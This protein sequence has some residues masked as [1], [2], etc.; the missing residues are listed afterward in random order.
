MDGQRA[1]HRTNAGV[2]APMPLMWHHFW[3]EMRRRRPVHRRRAL[4][5]IKIVTDSPLSQWVVIL[6]RKALVLLHHE[7]VDLGAMH[8]ILKLKLRLP[9]H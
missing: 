8:I 5:E 6:I 1:Q 2:L 9:H 3:T 7:V 4:I